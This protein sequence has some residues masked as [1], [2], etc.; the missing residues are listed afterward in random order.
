MYN[1][2]L[3]SRLS[4]FLGRMAY[5]VHAQRKLARTRSRWIG[6]ARSQSAAGL[7]LAISCAERV[8]R[9]I[10]IDDEEQKSC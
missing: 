4:S 9:P 3:T 6:G 1:G 8:S 10:D 2:V 5:G 7:D